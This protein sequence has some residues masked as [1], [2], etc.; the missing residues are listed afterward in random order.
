MNRKAIRIAAAISAALLLANCSTAT[1][2]Q[3]PLA[4]AKV[5]GPFALT[6]KDGRTVRDSDFA[7]KYRLVYF[8]YTF[9][10]DACPTDMAKLGQALKKLDKSDPALS[11]KLVPIFITVDPERDTPKVVGEFT[12]NFHPRMIGLT[13][14]LDAIKQVAREYS[15][16][17]AKQ[18]PA[19][20]GG[21]LVDHSRV[22][23]LM[24][25]KG[26]PIAPITSDMSVDEIIET[27]KR[28]A[29]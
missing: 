24:G 21:Y 27:I 3:P 10:P 7:G 16:Y 22:I 13:G 25:P 20:G 23:Y 8:G 6:D 18:P 2:Q 14:S 19:P 17:F 5:G 29:V 9:C 15:V 12:A 26:E 4:G 28:W 11:A 1:P